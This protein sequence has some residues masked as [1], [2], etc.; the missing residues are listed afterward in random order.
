MGLRDIAFGKVLDFLY[1][2]STKWHTNRSIQLAQIWA[3]GC[4][5]L[6]LSH[7]INGVDKASS[8]CPNIETLMCLGRNPLK[9]K[10]FECNLLKRV[11]GE[12]RRED[13]G[14]QTE[15]DEDD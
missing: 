4:P 5:C 11:D 9:F 1:T 14:S 2:T 3:T 15:E 12:S 7:F 13:R 6:A 10:S 8:Y